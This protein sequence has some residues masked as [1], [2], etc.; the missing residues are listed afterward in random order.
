MPKLSQ[1][2]SSEITGETVRRYRLAAGITIANA[3]KRVFVDPRTWR[4]WESA[5]VPPFI[6][7]NIWKLFLLQ[8]NLDHANV[9][10]KRETLYAHGIKVND[11]GYEMDARGLD[12]EHSFEQRLK[13][14]A[15]HPHPVTG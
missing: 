10:V 5:A 12:V 15:E 9:V 8:S 13:W 7:K 14:K 3:A 6:P 2:S 11:R 1:P 4:R